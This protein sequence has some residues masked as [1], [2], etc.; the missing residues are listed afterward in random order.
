MP[1]VSQAGFPDSAAMTQ[2][3]I[4][5]AGISGLAAATA[6]AE[7]HVPV[8]LYEASTSAGGRARSS[9]EAGMGSCDHGLHVIDGG[10][11]ELQRYLQRVGA[12][13]A[14]VATAHPLPLPF[15][16]VM[17]YVSLARGLLLGSGSIA[18]TVSPESPLRSQW[19]EP[20]SRLWLQGHAHAL[21]ARAMRQ[22]LRRWLRPKHRQYYVTRDSLSVG[23]IDP[24]L[25]YLE[26]HG[27][28]VYFG[29][30]L[31]AIT[32]GKNTLK[33]LKFSRKQIELAES[34]VVILAVPP[35]ACAAFIPG[36]DTPA[37]SQAS[38]TYH[39]AL[40]HALPRSVMALSDAPM[41]LIRIEPARISVSSRVAND[42]W[43]A[44]PHALAAR[45]WHNMQQR[46]P[47]LHDHPMPTFAV[48]REKWA[49]HGVQTK[50]LTIPPLPPRLLLAGDWL[51]A[52]QPATLENAARH[53]HNA[54]AQAMALLPP[55][56]RHRQSSPAVA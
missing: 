36:L 16:P 46:Y 29:H 44:D 1:L 34:D 54:A 11:R 27:A 20:L 32:Q 24:A 9:A 42:Q 8:T 3:H 41:D 40:T 13:Q 2:V 55:R 50:R 7:K 52:T 28:G 33:T 21:P 43:H 53:G 14:L 31:K 4:I 6:L 19:L 51:D 25:A 47:S 5:G 39:F 18:H 38:I 10:A 35:A 12:Q 56:P 26:Y 49:G 17:D 45:I 48:R 37:T 23:L 15:A 22:L 30:A